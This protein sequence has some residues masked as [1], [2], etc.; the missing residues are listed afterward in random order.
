MSFNKTKI[1]LFLSLFLCVTSVNRE[2]IV[3][4]P[5]RIIPNKISN[6][7]TQELKQIYNSSKFLDE[8][9]VYKIIT[10]MK[11][12]DP[13][14][15][16]LAILN[17]YSTTLLLGEL[18][19]FEEK[20]FPS[21][22]YKGY[23]YNKSLSFRNV[24]LENKKPYSDMSKLHIGEEKI[25]LFT[26]MESI[27]NRKYTCF[28]NFQ[29]QFIE[30][31]GDNKNNISLGLNIGLNLEEENYKINFMKQIYDNNMISKYAIS[32]DY[33]SDNEGF[34]ILGK[35]L[36]EILPKKY[37]ENN[38]KSFYSGQPK[39]MSIINFDI[40]FDEIYSV[41]E[42]GD[43]F[44]LK[45][46]IRAN[47]ALTIGLII[48]TR[49]YMNFIENIF[50]NEYLEIN[51]CQK[52]I[53]TSQNFVVFSCFESNKINFAKFPTLYFSKKAE[54]LIFEFNW[55]ELF[56]KMENKYYFKIIFPKDEIGLWIL[57]KPLINKYSLVYDGED[58]TIGFYD[59]KDEININKDWKM[60]LNI[61]KVLL[62]I[63]LFIAFIFLVA[64]TFYYLGKKYNLI[65]RK[66]ANE[67]DEDYYYDS[68]FTS[69]HN[70]KDINDKNNN[71]IKKQN[72]ELRDE[73]KFHSNILL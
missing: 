29:F 54:N 34:I 55:K 47:L 10:P 28:S 52:F 44:I 11:I 33:T 27:K 23:I 22:I 21:S 20:I 35:A 16:V 32:F 3:I 45:N 59:K 48:G 26:D 5:F 73:S 49:E 57:G 69:S 43:K 64:I 12:G 36:H 68:S 40:K 58:K 19:N 38:Y 50:F 9:F 8:N 70:S 2:S 71:E 18:E 31:L 14:Q 62:I 72:L 51:L 67:L 56:K 61:S 42:D 53:Y 66:L 25:Y 41:N 37:S 4:F 46:K 63:I 65:R 15:D 24:T 60:E 1:V 17:M 30:Q 7:K 6:L 13:P 39:K